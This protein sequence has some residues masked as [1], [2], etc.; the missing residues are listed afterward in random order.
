MKKHDLIFIA[1]ALGVLYVLSQ[2]QPTG[3]VVTPQLNSLL[4]TTLQRDA[5]SAAMITT[6]SAPITST[7]IPE[8][9]V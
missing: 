3:A 4:Q 8:A 5:N 1:I 7:L 6:V 2:S 9:I